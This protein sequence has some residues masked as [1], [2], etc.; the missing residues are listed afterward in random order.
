MGKSDKEDNKKESFFKK[1]WGNI[2]IIL[3]LLVVFVIF[4]F[5]NYLIDNLHRYSITFNNM[6]GLVFNIINNIFSE[7]LKNI[8]KFIEYTIYY[9]TISFSFLFCIYNLKNKISKKGTGYRFLLDFAFVFEIFYLV[10]LIFNILISSFSS[11]YQIKWIKDL[12]K[13]SFQILIV[14][15]IVYILNSLIKNVLKKNSSILSVVLL[16][17]FLVGWL[18]IKNF[19]L[20]SLSVVVINQFMS[21]ED[22]LSI[23]GKLKID[24][25][26]NILNEKKIKQQLAM[27][28]LYFNIFI[29]FLYIFIAITQEWWI[30][31]Y[32]FGDSSRE[33]DSFISIIDKGLTRII[34]IEVVIMILALFLRH[35]K[36]DLQEELLK[37]KKSFEYKL[38]KFMEKYI[39]RTK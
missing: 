8:Y 28:K 11:K 10:S 14:V 20:V 2:K 18:S 4:K 19:G 16:I 1:Y 34:L 38:M 26:N 27:N 39:I 30:L 21:Y 24:F 32:L 9:L 7:N 6:F 3:T 29:V 17:V 33:G 13:F 35:N 23:Y 37:Y 36:K 15:L 12:D 5:F 25:D 31:G 22:V